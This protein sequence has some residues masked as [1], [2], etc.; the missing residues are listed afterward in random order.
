MPIRSERLTKFLCVTIF[1]FSSCSI[2]RSSSPVKC[3]D[4]N[5]HFPDLT[6][7]SV[8]DT[9]VDSISESDPEDELNRRNG[10]A[11]LSR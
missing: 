10:G 9:V 4:V 6:Q 8:L 7:I 1:L 2:T 5:W 3:F 11:P